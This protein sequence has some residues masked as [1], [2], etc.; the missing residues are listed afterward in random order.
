MHGLALN[1]SNSLDLFGEIVPCGIAGRGVTTISEM[2]ARTIG[3]SMV[4]PVLT[5]ELS[6]LLLPSIPWLYEP[7]ACNSGKDSL[8]FKV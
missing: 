1:V 8:E 2:I 5:E 6:R 3:T 4:R 7:I